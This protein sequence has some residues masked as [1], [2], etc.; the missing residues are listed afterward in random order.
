MVAAA[1]AALP[2]PSQ[3]TYESVP[4]FARKCCTA[5]PRRL[6]RSRPPKTRTKSWKLSTRVARLV[7]PCAGQPTNAAMEVLTLAIV[8]TPLGLSST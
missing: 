1:V 5:Y 8:R 6:R 7:V 2:A 4:P 3:T